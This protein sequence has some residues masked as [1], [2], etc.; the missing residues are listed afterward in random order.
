MAIPTHLIL[1]FLGAGKTTAIRHLLTQ[2]PADERWAVLVNEFGEVGI[3]GALLRDSG[4]FVREVPGGCM[5]CAAGLPMQ[6]GLNMLIREARPDR[7]LIEPTGLGH[8]ARVLSTLRG[9]FYRDVLD[10]RASVTLVD[11]R[12][13]EEAR[14]RDN[15]NFRDQVAAADVLVASKADLCS[16]DQ[17]AGFWA[18]S[19]AQ[20]PAKQR[21][22][23]IRQG[24]LP[25]GWLDGP[26]GTATFADPHAHDAMIKE[27]LPTFDDLAFSVASGQWV[28]RENR[29]QGYASLGWALPAATLFQTDRLY[30]ALG[31]AD[32][33]R[34][35][36]VVHTPSGWQAVNGQEGD[37]ATY[38]IR[39]Q[40]MAR[41]ELIADR[42][43]DATCW[44]RRLRDSVVS[45][46]GD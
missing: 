4:A 39:E 45:A 19:Q 3:D 31:S 40:T 41:I 5:C 37:L 30:R 23:T 46:S 29:G 7:L 9:E 25:L 20:Q 26:G 17:L 33:R 32:L 2:K 42:P 36:A 38:P 44:E 11:P 6:M 21:F 35:K 12:R 27:A 28:C 18:W 43:L 1:G 14:V 24:Q 22:G 13:L 34:V 10:L 15:I 16:D 8:P